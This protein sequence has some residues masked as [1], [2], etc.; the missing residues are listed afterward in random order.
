MSGGD[1]STA[2]A[3]RAVFEHG[4][5]YNPAWKHYGK[6][7]VSV[8]C[9]KC[10]RADLAVSIGYESSDL[11][12]ACVGAMETAIVAEVRISNAKRQFTENMMRSRR[13]LLSDA[14]RHKPH[15]QVPEFRCWQSQFWC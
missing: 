3:L 10:G 2:A 13:V 9:D 14:W 5:Y 11:C 12:M 7:T 4:T 6:S 8:V 15:R 1:P